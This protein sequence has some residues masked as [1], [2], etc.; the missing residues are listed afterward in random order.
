MLCKA[1]YEVPYLYM[2]L[3]FLSMILSFSLEE[4]AVVGIYIP[5]KKPILGSTNSSAFLFC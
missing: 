4:Q 5:R 3:A 2:E 1:I